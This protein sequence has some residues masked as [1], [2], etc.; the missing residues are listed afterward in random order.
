MFWANP[1]LPVLRHGKTALLSLFILKDRRIQKN[2]KGFNMNKNTN[3][4][5]PTLK[6]SNVYSMSFIC[7]MRPRKGRICTSCI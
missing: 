4:D 5:A 6:G 7:V 1:W 2:L 3:P